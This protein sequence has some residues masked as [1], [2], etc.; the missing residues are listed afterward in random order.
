MVPLKFSKR[1]N[2]YIYCK[3]IE[4]GLYIEHGFAIIITCIH[5]GKNCS[6]NQQVTIGHSNATS[7]PLIGHNVIIHA[8]AK[9]IGNVSIG[10]DDVV[11]ANAVP[12]DVP[13]HSIV[14]GVLVRVIKTR[15]SLD[16][17]WERIKI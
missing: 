5:I 7:C 3:D 1:L 15:K 10:N 11:E 6:I 13:N 16:E 4:G 8:G 9:V 14:A 2:L 17:P 12:N